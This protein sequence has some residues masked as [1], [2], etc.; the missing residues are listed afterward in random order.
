M[1][2]KR[3]PSLVLQARAPPPDPT[4]AFPSVL[5]CCY[6]PLLWGLGHLGQPAA[7]LL[8][9]CQR[10]GRGQG[11][12]GGVLGERVGSGGGTGVPVATPQQVV[13]AS[14]LGWGRTGRLQGVS[15][16]C[17]LGT[18]HGAREKAEG[19]KLG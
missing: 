1:Q 16:L 11:R 12:H 13:P 6:S 3:A 8:Q 10:V 2:A 9:L 17:A 15:L 18:E 5:C 14:S 7:G 19:K 4:S